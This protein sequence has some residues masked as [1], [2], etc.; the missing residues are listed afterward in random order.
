MKNPRKSAKEHKT[1]FNKIEQKAN[2]IIE[3]LSQFSFA[4]F[5][6]SYNQNEVKNEDIFILLENHKN[7][8][9]NERRQSTA[10]LYTWTIASLKAFHTD[11][12]TKKLL[13]ADITANFL[14]N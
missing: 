10:D 2:D 13:L 8:L 3:G 1:Y 5:E 14:L 7:R 9:E 12:R 6:K 4:N 11:G